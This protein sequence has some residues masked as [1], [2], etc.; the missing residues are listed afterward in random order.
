MKP[1]STFARLPHATLALALAFAFFILHSPFCISSRASESA[2]AFPAQGIVARSGGFQLDGYWVWDGSVI[3]GDDGLFHMFAS[4]WPK[5]ITFHP[6]WMLKSE[7]VHAT[8]DRIEG[9]YT[10]R[11]VVL[12]AR[13]AEYW[14]GR[15]THN[16]TIRKHGD[17]YLLFYMGSTH[18]LEDPEP[19]VRLTL[20][21][22]RCIVARANKRIGLATAKSP[23]GPW[24][25]LDHPI[26]D[27]KPGTFY[28]LLTSNPAPVVHEDGSVLM[29]FKSRRF[30]GTLADPRQSSMMLGLARAKHYSGPYEVIGDAPLFAPDRFGEV[31]DPFVWQSPNG[32]YE[33]IAKDMTGK[34]CGEKH[35][36]IYARS[37]DGENWTLATPPKSYTKLLRWD[38]GTTQK[39]GQLERPFLYL[40]NGYPRYLFCAAADGPGGFN[41]ASKTWV[42]AI[43]LGEKTE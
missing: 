34:L 19:N 32:G 38:D 22:P 33:L 35:A 27:C 25:R 31:E 16:P 21:E 20:Q 28:S 4:R 24:T 12:P 17:T 26:L 5:N 43:P 40:E 6:G 1:S 9:P 29:L 36:A 11:D 18:P 41:N 8:A 15:A 2:P 13:G 37:P 3:K 10:F 14:D 30:E 39:M 23:Y 42:V 7:V